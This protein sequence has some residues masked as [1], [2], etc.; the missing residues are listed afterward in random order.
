MWMLGQGGMSNHNVLKAGTI[1][2]A[3][4]LGL[5]G[6]LG[7]IATGKLADL[8]VLDRNPLQNIRNTTAI[9]Y[10]VING[11]IFDAATMAQT[12][13]HPAPAPRAHWKE[14]QITA[15]QVQA[16]TDV[17]GMAT[18]ADTSRIH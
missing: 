7:S 11:R 17:R 18:E 12:G 1:W 9:R 10:V 3:E 15:A 13:N 5:D 8:L 4:Y 6:D 16:M 14:G 2:G